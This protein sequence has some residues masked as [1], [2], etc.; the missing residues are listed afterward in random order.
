M[1]YK[2]YGFVIIVMLTVKLRTND[3]ATA[4]SGE[5]ERGK[6]SDVLKQQPF[7]M[8]RQHQRSR[9]ELYLGIKG[10]KLRQPLSP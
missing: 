4:K 10:K 8:S 7:R 9:P 3:V 5:A 6:L 1:H 2:D